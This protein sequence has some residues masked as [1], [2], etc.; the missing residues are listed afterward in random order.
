MREAI[1]KRE[2]GSKRSKMGRE[3]AG[4]KSAGCERGQNGAKKRVAWAKMGGGYVESGR[5]LERFARITGR[6]ESAGTEK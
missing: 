4:L 3:E 2:G 1:A 5:V 6:M